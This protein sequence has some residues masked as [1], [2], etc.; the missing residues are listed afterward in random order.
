MIENIRKKVQERYGKIATGAGVASC[1]S[2][3][4]SSCGCS[5]QT[6]AQALSKS[7][8]YSAAE[9]QSIPQEAN[10]GL[11]CGNPLAL[12]SLRQGETVLDLGS[13]GGIDCFLA[14]QQV[15]PQGRVIGVDMTPDMINLARGNASK[16]NYTNVEFRLGEIE[17]LP[18]ADGSVDV[19]ISNCVIN[20][21]VDKNQVF[22]EI[23]RVLKPGGRMMVSDIVLT[24]EL[25]KEVEES[26]T[27]Y[28]GCIAGALQK[29]DYLNAIK[30][31]G[32]SGVK[33]LAETGVP[34]DLW[35]DVPLPND[36]ITKEKIAKEQ[37]KEVLGMIVSA[38]VYAEK[39][40]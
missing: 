15:G 13:G 1:C 32:F 25:P 2:P 17:H 33:I 30:A 27:A 5:Q 23:F 16:G 14:S 20:L 28:T 19:A 12:A 38:K 18:V 31:A 26:V 11:G 37:I 7:A 22:R 3:A 10:L 9:L 4:K 29:D 34:V 35:A 40:A 6:A 21:S 39:K 24:R 8:G 36:S